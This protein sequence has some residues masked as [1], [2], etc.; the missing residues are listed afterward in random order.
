MLFRSEIYEPV[1]NFYYFDNEPFIII[2]N[3]SDLRPEVR[4]NIN[5]NVSFPLQVSLE[6]G[7]FEQLEFTQ[8]IDYSY[9]Y[10]D[11]E[12]LIIIISDIV[13]STF[14]VIQSDYYSISMDEATEYLLM[15]AMYNNP[16]I[17]N[18]SYEIIDYVTYIFEIELLENWAIVLFGDYTGDIAFYVTDYIEVDYFSLERENDYQLLDVIYEYDT[19]MLLYEVI[20]LDYGF[21]T[22]LVIY[23]V[24]D[25]ISPIN[26]RI[27]YIDK[28]VG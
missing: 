16:S 1:T 23:L 15:V 24:E 8:E 20:N 14:D 6:S 28:A 5:D 11:N 26:Y 2:C 9:S 18:S 10:K 3:L 13:E 21:S 27:M 7:T 17:V 19:I 12:E 25:Q 4:I 22:S